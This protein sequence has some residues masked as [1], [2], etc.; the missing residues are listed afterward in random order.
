MRLFLQKN[1]KIIFKKMF[2]FLC[3][4]A[5]QIPWGLDFQVVC[6]LPDIENPGPLLKKKKKRKKT[7]K[8]K[9]LNPWAMSLASTT[10]NA[11]ILK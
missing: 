10:I 8:T 9:K 1:L 7:E 6:E 11:L 5:C 2:L 3:L 4:Q